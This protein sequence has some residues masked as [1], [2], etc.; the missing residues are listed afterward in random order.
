MVGRVERVCAALEAAAVRYLIVGGVAVVLHGYLRT[1]ADLDLIIGL[2]ADNASR[3]MTALGALG[4]QPRAPVAI[5]AYADGAQRQRWID[6]KGLTV[7]SRWDPDDPGAELDLF[8][9]EPLDFEAAFARAVVFDLTTT[10]ARVVALDDL[11]ALKRRAGRP[12]DLDD[13]AALEAIA[14]GDR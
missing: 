12:R 5:T 3:A 11:L 6:E 7:F 14:A 4:Y 9:E 8:V 1:T 10:Q 13:I 2:D